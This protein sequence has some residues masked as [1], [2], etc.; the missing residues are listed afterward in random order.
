[1]AEIDFTV[2]AAPR[3]TPLGEPP[4]SRTSPRIPLPPAT[5]RPDA[6]RTR[7]T[8]TR[9]RPRPPPFVTNTFAEGP[10]HTFVTNTFAEGPQH[11]FATNKTPPTAW[12]APCM[13]YRTPQVRCQAVPRRRQARRDGAGLGRDDGGRGV[14]A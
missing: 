13:R 5:S 12:H 4:R 10:Q 6:H 9:E 2:N 8:A 3:P 7:T 11:T 14:K 1:M